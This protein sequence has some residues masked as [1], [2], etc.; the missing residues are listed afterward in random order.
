VERVPGLSELFLKKT[1][2]ESAVRVSEIPSLFVLPAGSPL[3]APLSLLASTGYADVMQALRRLFRF[4]VLD[5]PPVLGFA[6]TALIAPRAGGVVLV[7]AAGERRRS[8][9]REIK[10]ILDGVAVK[11]L[12][13][14]LSDTRKDAGRPKGPGRS[15]AT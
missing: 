10:R 11:L 8:E 7:V 12:G 6:D 14:V 1:D 9:V 15:G 5:G 3:A 13:I 2:I 4:I